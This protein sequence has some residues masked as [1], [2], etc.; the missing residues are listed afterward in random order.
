M[1][2][3]GP[4]EPLPDHTADDEPEVDEARERSWLVKA[5]PRV[6]NDTDFL[7]PQPRIVSTS[8]VEAGPPFS[9]TAVW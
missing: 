3:S 6:A 7:I 5:K 4:D 1:V 2:G 9:A 8:P